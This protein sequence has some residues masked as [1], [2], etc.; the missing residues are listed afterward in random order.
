M[1]EPQYLTATSLARELK[2]DRR[3]VKNVDHDA[4]VIDGRSEI[5]LFKRDRVK[6][7]AAAIRETAER[8]AREDSKNETK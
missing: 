3:N 1:A 4:T 5:K 7:L 8:Y 2:V 6:A